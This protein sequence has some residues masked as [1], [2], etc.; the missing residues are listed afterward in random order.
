[1][2]R[3]CQSCG[4]PMKK[5]PRGGGTDADGT[6]S[7]EYCSY[8]Y[9]DGTFPSP[10]IRTAAD[11][12]KAACNPITPQQPS[13]ALVPRDMEGTVFSTWPRGGFVTRMGSWG[14]EPLI[15]PPFG[16]EDRGAQGGRKFRVAEVQ[17][18]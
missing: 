12:G 9:Q 17:G 8:C 11:T 4:M 10:G 7:P 18:P 16:P 3:F 1:M 14:E 2:N 13:R 5:D 6:R 15:G